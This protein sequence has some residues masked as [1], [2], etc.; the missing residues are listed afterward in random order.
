MSQVLH[1]RHE[2]CLSGKEKGFYKP[3]KGK[4]SS[5]GPCALHKWCCSLKVGGGQDL[6]QKTWD[7]QSMNQQL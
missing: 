1:N 2:D 7:L 3:L 6:E 4:G 5:N